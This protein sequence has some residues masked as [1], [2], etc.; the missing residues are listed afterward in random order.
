MGAQGWPSVKRPSKG[1]PYTAQ[2]EENT[3]VSTL[4]RRMAA[5][6]EMVPPTLFW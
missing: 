5:R 1:G 2:E 6:S 3:R 4:W